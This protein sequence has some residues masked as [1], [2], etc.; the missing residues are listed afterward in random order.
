MVI[1]AGAA[2]VPDDDVDLWSANSA[3]QFLPMAA[4]EPAPYTNK[5]IKKKKTSLAA[6]EDR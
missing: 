1:A 5:Y 4:S 3:I 6:A 2:D